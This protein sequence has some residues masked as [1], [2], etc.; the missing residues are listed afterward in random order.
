MKFKVVDQFTHKLDNVSTLSASDAPLSANASRF[1][2]LLASSLLLVIGAALCLMIF[3]INSKTIDSSLALSKK[4][5]VMISF[6]EY[7]LLKIESKKQ[8]KCL[9]ILYGKESAWNPLAVGNLDGTHRV[10]GIPQGK[11]EYLSRVDGYK[12]ID[13]G[14]S[15]IAHKY[16]LDNDGYI[17]ACAALDHFKKWNWH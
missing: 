2:G 9:A 7:A 11:S 6:K 15:F 1:S 13:W 14:L 12:Q 5:V 17:N 16:K 8:Y 10:Y 3:S 4:P